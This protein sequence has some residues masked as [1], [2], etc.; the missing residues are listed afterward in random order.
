MCTRDNEA[1]IELDFQRV[2]QKVATEARRERRGARKVT[3]TEMES[4]DATILLPDDFSL[5]MVT[6]RSPPS[7]LS[8]VKNE[9]R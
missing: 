3:R 7:K 6:A 5:A 2:K 4:R 8:H 9:L 1:P